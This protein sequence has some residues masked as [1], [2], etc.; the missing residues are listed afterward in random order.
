MDGHDID[1][2]TLCG[3]LARARDLGATLD[4]LAK[5]IVLMMKVKA[6]SI[7]LLDE[8]NRVLEIAAAYGLSKEYT[9]KGP[10]VL[11]KSEAD[12]R[13][14]GGEAISTADITKESHVLYLEEAEKEGIRSILSVPLT[15]ET[16]A[17]GVI[18]VYTKEVHP[19]SNADIER[20]RAIAALGG[21]LVDRARIWDE[22][23]ALVSISRSITSTLSLESVL[24]MIVEKAAKALRLR[25]AS[26]R[27]LDEDR[28]ELRVKAAY[29]LSQAYIE[30]GPVE[31]DKSPVD[32][33]CLEGNIIA[34]SE[35]ERDER[36]Q[37]RNEI[38]KEGIKAL[39]SVP[40]MVRGSAIG[41]LRVYTSVPC[42][43]SDSDKEF[44]SAL[45]SQGAIAIENARLFEH[46][47]KE[48]D[49]LSK[50]IWKWYDWGERFP[51]V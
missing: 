23:R 7:R 11:E 46:V 25:A 20:L 43:F 19:F 14:L 16:R 32:R 35:I 12:Q 21:L 29:G 6:S 27:L 45:A 50:D 2:C 4:I 37:Y 26:I 39:L 51:R 3:D 17:I 44:L 38:L 34:I 22:M 5:K 8:K 13:V 15:A 48:Y 30:K 41:V 1:L 9:E 33:E 40:L 47:K 42:E 36:L 28:A 10:L 49:V 24:Q 31:V 18:R